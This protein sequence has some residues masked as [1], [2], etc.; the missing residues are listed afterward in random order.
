MKVSNQ[1][2]CV[3]LCKSKP[4]CNWFTFSSQ[5]NSCHLFK[6]CFS[7]D[8]EICPDCRSSQINCVETKPKC[9]IQGECT[10]KT[11]EHNELADTAEGCLMLCKSTSTCKWFTFY[12]QFSKCVL[13]KS[14]YKID[15]SCK[16]CISGE[17]S[18]SGN[19]I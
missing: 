1:T 12:K 3:E 7:L 2:E 16:T 5:G 6:N 17:I 18:C 4:V 14:C 11:I 10:G 19:L 9:N 13:F 8:L 15:S